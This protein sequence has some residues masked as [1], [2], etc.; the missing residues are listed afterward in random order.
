MSTEQK[1]TL[2]RNALFKLLAAVDGILPGYTYLNECMV[3]ARA[4][5]TATAEEG[6]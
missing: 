3:E 2:V 1:L 5:L 4:A 6:E